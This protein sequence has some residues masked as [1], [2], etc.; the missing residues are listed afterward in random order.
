MGFNCG[1]GHIQAGESSLEAI[2]RE[3]K[4]EIGIDICN[5][6]IIKVLE[7]KPSKNKSKFTDIY[8]VIKEVDINDIKLQLEEVSE[9]KYFSLNELIN[10]YNTN[11][12][13]F[14]NHPFFPKLIDIVNRL[15]T[16]KSSL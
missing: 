9:V 6:Q 5:D 13:D 3:T 7:V 11:N 1:W 12:S 4:E 2:V 8:L 15:I 14:I 16:K 10:I